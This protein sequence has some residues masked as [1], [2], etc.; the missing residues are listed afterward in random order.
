MFT[1]LKQIFVLTS[2]VYGAMASE[3]SLIQF[4]DMINFQF[5]F[6]FWDFDSLQ[7]NNYG[8]WCGTG[9]RGDPLDA[10]DE[11]CRVHDKYGHSVRILWP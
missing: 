1:T 10:I 3:R 4:N 5:S 11:C 7:F 2:I 8:C 6:D 9:G